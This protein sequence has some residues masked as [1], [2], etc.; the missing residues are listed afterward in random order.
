MQIMEL[1]EI[2]RSFG[3]LK[4]LEKTCSINPFYAI[5]LL[6]SSHPEVFYK[7][8]FLEISQNS[9]KNTCARVFFLI[10]LQT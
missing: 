4:N 1:Y 10:K 3:L 6:R 2:L 8:V 5:N 9:Q 7:K